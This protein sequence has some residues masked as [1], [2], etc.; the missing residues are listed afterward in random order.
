MISLLE[1]AAAQ[2]LIP[3]LE[4]HETSVGIAVDVSH[5]AATAET[6][7]V[8]AEAVL[9]AVDGKKFLFEVIARDDA[10]IVGKGSHKRA[11][12]SKGKIEAAANE[13]RTATA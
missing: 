12:V 8:R 2:I 4:A 10:G 6:G 13:R 5:D 1:K 11:I 3:S 7:T 9:K